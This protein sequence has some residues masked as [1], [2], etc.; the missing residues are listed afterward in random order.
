MMIQKYGLKPYFLTTAK[1]Y[2][3]NQSDSFQFNLKKSSSQL[4]YA[5]L[6]SDRFIFAASNYKKRIPS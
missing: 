2:S 3:K 5:I 6:R 4:K 1:I